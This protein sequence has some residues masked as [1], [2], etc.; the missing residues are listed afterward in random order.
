MKRKKK[1]KKKI[2]WAF[3]MVL[4][5]GSLVCFTG[6]VSLSLPKPHFLNME[7]SEVNVLNT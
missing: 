4:F 1:K 7:N 2:S 5:L 3:C 6:F